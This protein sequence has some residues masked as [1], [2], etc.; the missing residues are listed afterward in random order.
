MDKLIFK[1]SDSTLADLKAAIERNPVRHIHLFS[2]SQGKYE[3][4]ITP[5]AEDIKNGF[6]DYILFTFKEEASK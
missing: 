4:R 1:L 3:I 2:L 6:K 5:T